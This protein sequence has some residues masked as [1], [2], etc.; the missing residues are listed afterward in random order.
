[1]SSVNGRRGRLFDYIAAVVIYEMCAEEPT[2]TVSI[3]IASQQYGMNHMLL[4]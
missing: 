3:S 1:L 2:A 4:L